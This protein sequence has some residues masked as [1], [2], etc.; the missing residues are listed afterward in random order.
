[1]SA[2][3]AA[4]RGSGAFTNLGSRWHHERS[5]ESIHGGSDMDDVASYGGL[6]WFIERLV[7][8]LFIRPD[9]VRILT[10]CHQQLLAQVGSVSGAFSA[11]VLRAF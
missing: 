1:M 6:G 4:S 3:L 8:W 9:V 2:V 7:N 11:S 5:L 10:N